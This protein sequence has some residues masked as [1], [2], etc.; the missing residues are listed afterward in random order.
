[1][2]ILFVS[3]GN[4]KDGISPIVRNQGQSLIKEGIRLDFFTI[5]GKGI[6]SY[7]KHILILRSFLKKSYYDIIHAH[8]G[9]CGI[10]ALMARRKEK[11][12]V[13]FMGSD[14]IGTVN[15]NDNISLSGCFETLINKIF[16]KYFFDINIVKSQNIK[17]LLFN[18]TESH[19][20]PNGVDFLQFYPINKQE[21]RKDLNIPLDLK[22]VLFAANPENYTKNYKL[23]VNAIKLLPDSMVVLKSV[24]NVSQKILNKYYNAADVILLTSFHEGSPNVIKEAIA[25]NRPIVSTDVGDVKQNIKNIKGC[26]ICSFDPKNVAEKI[27]KALMEENSPGRIKNANLDSSVVANKIINLY[28]QLL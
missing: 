9:F 17:D 14:L 21:A 3:S 5:K 4:A 20:I 11:I 24:Y 15:K 28:N 22:I 7:I 26:F 18:K 1:M 2:K 23:A 13:S 10:V 25:C 8:Y 27:N 16:A 12:I 6:I 19:I